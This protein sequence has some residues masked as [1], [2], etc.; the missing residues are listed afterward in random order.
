MKGGTMTWRRRSLLLGAVVVV[1]IGVVAGV[2]AARRDGQAT[3]EGIKQL[4]L[5][6]TVGG[7]ALNE[8]SNSGMLADVKTKGAAQVLGGFYGAEPGMG[9]SIGLLAALEPTQEARDALDSLAPVGPARSTELNF[10]HRG[11]DFQCRTYDRATG[12]RWYDGHVAAAATGTQI[13]ADAFRE[14]VTSAYDAML[15]AG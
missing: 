14:A 8:Q 10:Q 7:L 1:L 3:L 4:H 9:P 11:V 13:D 2:V 12:C 15:R 6:D 5:P